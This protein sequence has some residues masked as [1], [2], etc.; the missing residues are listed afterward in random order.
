MPS[1]LIKDVSS[2]QDYTQSF[3][4][5][6]GL[7]NTISHIITVV[8]N[9]VLLFLV[10][11]LFYKICRTIFRLIVKPWIRKLEHLELDIFLKKGTLKALALMMTGILLYNLFPVFLNL[12]EEGRHPLRMLSGILIIVAFLMLVS[13]ILH[14]VEYLAK[15]SIEYEKKPISSYIQV[16]MILAYIF[17]IILIISMLIGKSPMT[18]IT[19]FGAGMAIFLL[20]F[21]DL[22]LG[23]VTSVQISVND[24]VRV[25]DWIIVYNFNADGEVEAINLTTVKVRNWDNTV[26][27]VPTYALVS[28][29]FA[30]VRE[31]DELKIRRFKQH[32]LFDIRTIKE[33]NNDFIATLRKKGLFEG[34]IE[35][36]KWQ[37]GKSYEHPQ[38]TSITNLGLY[39]KYVESYLV[40]HPGVDNGYMVVRHLQPE[41]KGQPLELYAFVKSV[42]FKPLNFIMADIFEHLYTVAAAFDLELFQ[43]PTG[44][45]FKELSLSDSDVPK[46]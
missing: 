44:D 7:G 29:G 30:N 1:E 19:A 6:L 12:S 37:E 25:G 45:D 36:L 16:A 23:L 26:A 3:I 21:K 13:R 14:S 32:L 2:L 33:V 20:V 34:D 9:L 15:H 27:N 40:K 41:G 5:E 10:C 18:I 31:R 24:M 22:I 11:F 39:R 17:C 38:M 43:Q 35:E 8:I 46:E 4:N 42:S 28:N